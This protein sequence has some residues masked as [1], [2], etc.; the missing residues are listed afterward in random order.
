MFL[1]HLA[2]LLR[3]V[4]A[5]RL[6]PPAGK[7]ADRPDEGD[8]IVRLACD[9]T[10]YNRAS[11][12]TESLLVPFQF[13]SMSEPMHPLTVAS[14]VALIALA[15]PINLGLCRQCALCEAEEPS[16]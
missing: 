7:K 6:I 16:A 9:S 10:R 13:G 3:I 15:D 14:G 5:H 11:G 2:Q 12:G 1:C 8:G 4:A